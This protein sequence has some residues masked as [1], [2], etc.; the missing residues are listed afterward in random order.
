MPSESRPRLSVAYVFEISADI[1]S[2]LPCM[3][4][5][6]LLRS[7]SEFRY[8]RRKQ[9]QKSLVDTARRWESDPSTPTLQGVACP[10]S[11]HFCGGRRQMMLSAGVPPRHRSGRECRCHGRYYAGLVSW[12]S[13][14]VNITGVGQRLPWGRRL[15]ADAGEGPDLRGSRSQPG[16]SFTAGRLTPHPTHA[17]LSAGVHQ[18]LLSIG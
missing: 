1:W 5:R 6:R 16:V 9:P 4:S 10:E 18:R 13:C 17:N 2:H 15:H 7:D 12:G 3:V 11:S 14:S 8:S